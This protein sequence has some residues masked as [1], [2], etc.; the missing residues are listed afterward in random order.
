MAQNIG[1]HCCAR[2]SA[3]CHMSIDLKLGTERISALQMAYKCALMW[4]GEESRNRTWSRGG[5]AGLR[6]CGV[7]RN[8]TTPCSREYNTTTPLKKRLQFPVEGRR[9]YCLFSALKYSTIVE[10][11]IIIVNIIFQR[12]PYKRQR[13]VYCCPRRQ[14]PCLS[15]PTDTS[16]KTHAQP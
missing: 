5:V 9:N 11:V 1:Q 16:R 6:G 2:P 13:E 15:G 7:A 12:R 8:N 14:N 3:T 10:A 4:N